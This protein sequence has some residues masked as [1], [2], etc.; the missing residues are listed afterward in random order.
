MVSSPKF[1]HVM[2]Y[3]YNTTGTCSRNIEIEITEDGKIGDVVFA[4]GC[5]GNLQGIAALVKGMTPAE[6]A[7]KLRGIDCKGNGTS[8][9]D[10]L[11][12]ALESV[13]K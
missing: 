6:A 13:I 1:Y 3:N 11:A 4:G 12:R 2:K 10:Q 5:H 9:P 7:A 8:C